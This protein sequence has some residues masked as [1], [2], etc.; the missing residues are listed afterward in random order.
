MTLCFQSFYDHV[1]AISILATPGNHNS[2][3]AWHTWKKTDW[4]PLPPPARL[5]IFAKPLADGSTAVVMLNRGPATVDAKV[6]WEMIKMGKPTAWKSAKV[7]DLWQHMNRGSFP[8]GFTVKGLESH[9]AAFLIVTQ[10]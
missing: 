10:A 6:T 4:T 1:G 8:E 3:P 2:D 7:R 9:A 5:Q